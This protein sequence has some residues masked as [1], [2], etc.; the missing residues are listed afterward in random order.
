MK[1]NTLTALAALALAASFSPVA[2]AD[3]TVAVEYN[4]HHTATTRRFSEYEA[5]GVIQSTKYGTFDA[6]LQTAS[7]RAHDFTD[8]LQGAEVG[9][10]YGGSLPFASYSARI[11]AGTFDNIDMGTR[12]GKA[13]YAL[14]SFELTR[15]LTSTVG[16]YV[17]VS[18]SH[19]FN[20]DAIS[21]MNRF[22]AGVDI[23][24]MPKTSLRVGGSTFRSIDASQ[25]GVVVVLSYTL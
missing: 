21:A 12:T 22:Q 2:Q 19:G 9:Y 24:V 10:T 15:P 6:H 3:T 8:H 13:N 14:A 4:Y 11:A 7:N 16:G 18:H 20:D 17:N 25:A 23:A 1:F 5:V